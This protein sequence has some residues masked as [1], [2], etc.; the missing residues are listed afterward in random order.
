M[1]VSEV[2]RVLRADT[3]DGHPALT[4]LTHDGDTERLS[5]DHVIAATG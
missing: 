1:R 5:A 2:A 3:T 4:A